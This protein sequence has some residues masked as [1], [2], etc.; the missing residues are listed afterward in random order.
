M[1][2]VIVTALKLVLTVPVGRNML[3]RAVGSGPIQAR[4]DSEPPGRRRRLANL[5]TLVPQAQRPLLSLTAS[6]TQPPADFDLDTDSDLGSQLRV[7]SVPPLRRPARQFNLKRPG[8]W[9]GCQ[10]LN[11]PRWRARQWGRSGGRPSEA[12]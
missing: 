5:E 8:T 1:V 9:P 10:K 7:D 2:Q 4:P 6:V 3:K 12:Q 11:T